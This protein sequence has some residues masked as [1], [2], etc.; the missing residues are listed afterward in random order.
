M[1]TAKLTDAE[2]DGLSG[3]DLRDAVARAMGWTTGDGDRSHY[4]YSPGQHMRAFSAWFSPPFDVSDKGKMLDLLMGLPVP[5]WI[6][7]DRNGTVSIVEVCGEYEL[8]LVTGPKSEIASLC[9]K[10]F[11]KL[12]NR[13]N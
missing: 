11:L 7:P 9:C 12:E 6:A 13:K 8:T 10:A 4:W 2:I 3:N 1:T 5:P